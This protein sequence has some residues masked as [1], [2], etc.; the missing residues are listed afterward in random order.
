MINIKSPAKINLALD[1]LYK[2]NDGFHEIDT[3]MAK[4]KLC[5]DILIEEHSDLKVECGDISQEKNLVYK[6]CMNFYKLTGI[7]PLFK[8]K[9]NKK[10]PQG[11]GLG[12]G[13][14][15]AGTILNFLG[16]KYNIDKKVLMKAGSMTGADVNFFLIDNAFARCTGKGEII[17]PVDG[18]VNSKVIIFKRNSSFSDTPSVYKNLKL[19]LKNP[20][21][22]ISGVIFDL[23]SGKIDNYYNKL[24]NVLETSAFS[25]YPELKENKE[26]LANKYDNVIMS[27]SGASFFVLTNENKKTE[28]LSDFSAKENLYVLTEFWRQN[29]KN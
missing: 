6:A 1:I 12:G 14:S 3:L 22:G 9:I 28:L 29:E 10:I 18:T 17:I 21:S 27:G 13:S 19:C 7:K 20:T 2:R 15:N 5:D 25:L 23:L 16:R 4:I 8:I 26:K 11:A 24:Y